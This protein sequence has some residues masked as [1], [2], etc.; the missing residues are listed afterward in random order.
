MNIYKNMEKKNYQSVFQ[1]QDQYRLR[2]LQHSGILKMKLLTLL[3]MA[4]SQDFKLALKIL[5]I[6][7]QLTLVNLLLLLVFQVPVKVISSTKWLSDIIITTDGK[8]RSRRQKIN[9]LTY[10]L[11]VNA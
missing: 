2:M 11:I 4:L 3:R 9:R 8:Q 5:M 10:T 1:D 6:S 7:F